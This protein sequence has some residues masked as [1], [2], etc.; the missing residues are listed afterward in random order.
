MT[1]SNNQSQTDGIFSGE[2]TSDKPQAQDDEGRDNGAG[3]MLGSA[4]EA[5]SHTKDEQE[6]GG[7]LTRGFAVA[8]AGFFR[9]A[10]LPRNI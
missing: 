6:T 4:T 3:G 10:R 8:V 7:L 2:T 9:C 5:E 1:A